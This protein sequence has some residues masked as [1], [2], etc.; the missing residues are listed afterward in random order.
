MSVLNL[1]ENHK[2][3][4]SIPYIPRLFEVSLLFFL[5]LRC[6]FW[7]KPIPSCPVE[8]HSGH[9]VVAPLCWIKITRYPRFL[10]MFGL[11]KNYI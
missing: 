6:D 7:S 2:K 5:D 3:H 10:D 8:P 9:D 11:K 4:L 1:L